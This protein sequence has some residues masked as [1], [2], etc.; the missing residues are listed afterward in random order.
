[1]D[2]SH[3]PLQCVKQ[4]RQTLAA[5]KLSIGLFLGA[6]C[7]CAIQVS[8]DGAEESTPLVPDING[9]TQLV[10]TE[11]ERSEGQSASFGRLKKI[12]A[13]DGYEAPNVE[14]ILS[15]I[16]ALRDAAGN[17]EV[18]GLNAGTL[19]EL[20]KEVCRVVSARVARELPTGTT[21]YHSVAKWVGS[22]RVPSPEIFTTNYDLLMEQALESMRVPFFDGFVGSARPFF[23]QR[24][25]E[26]D[27]AAND[28]LTLPDRWCRLWKLHGSIN[29]RFN[30]RTRAITRSRETADGEE[31]LIHPSQRKY[32]ESRRRPYS[33]MLDRLKHFI[34]N[35][36][37]P[38]ALLAIGH[39][40]SDDHLNE[41]IVESLR[42][43]PSAV[44]FALQYGDCA[45]HA[46]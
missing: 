24:T 7:P 27:Q 28:K 26:E 35:K 13:E 38:V 32:D 22:Y 44:C 8:R 19:D 3:D 16:R 36:K 12:L 4:L 41:T 5:D 23:D 40:F 6:G 37:E 46:S 43:N 18:R 45:F 34:R 2:E 39:S 31:L 10:S 9:L 25:I 29:W 11:M 15:C 17:G 14:R 30:R 42:S 20:D 21:P 33:V 1:M